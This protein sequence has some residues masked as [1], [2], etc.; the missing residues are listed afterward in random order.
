[1]RLF[2]CWLNCMVLGSVL[3]PMYGAGVFLPSR[4]EIRSKIIYI[5]D[6]GIKQLRMRHCQIVCSGV[7]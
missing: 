4:F 5:W 2:R 7:L 6:R 3:S 1:M